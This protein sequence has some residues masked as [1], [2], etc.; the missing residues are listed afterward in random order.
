M[1]TQHPFHHRGTLDA[2]DLLRADHDK[3]RQLFR[4][5]DSLRDID[6]EDERKSD[7]VDEICYE[8]TIHAMIEE[9]IFYPT[10]RLALGDGPIDEAEDEHASM[11]E[12]VLRL[13]QLYPGDEHFDVTLTVLAEEVADHMDREEADLFNAL[14]NSGIDLEGLCG[15]LIARKDALE[16]DLSAPPA[17]TE[18]QRAHEGV[19][20]IP[21]A[22][23]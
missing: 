10:V 12:L 7:L 23:N 6:D 5:F 20:R 13:E 21:R 9:E 3:V 8:L 18:P 1:S 19:R 14:R 16:D 22:P 2:L 15:Q 17:C 4:E 11:R